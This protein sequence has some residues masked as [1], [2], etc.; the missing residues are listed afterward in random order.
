MFIETPNILVPLKTIQTIY[1]T[2]SK[3]DYIPNSPI[4]IHTSD[5]SMSVAT[6]VQSTTK[7]T[8]TTLATTTKTNPGI[9]E[10]NYK[11]VTTF[12]HLPWNWPSS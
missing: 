11:K 2:V 4:K 3:I 1:N 8:L 7:P 6:Q 9:Q 5:P 10:K 12:R